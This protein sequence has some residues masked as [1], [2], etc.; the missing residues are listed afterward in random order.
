M[1]DKEASLSLPSG[2]PGDLTGNFGIGNSA[3]Q[4]QGGAPEKKV[5]LVDG[6]ETVDPWPDGSNDGSQPIIPDEDVSDIMT[7]D[8]IAGFD[9]TRPS[10]NKTLLVTDGLQR[11]T[12]QQTE[13][14]TVP[15][16]ISLVSFI[17]VVRDVSPSGQRAPAPGDTGIVGDPWVDLGDNGIVVNFDLSDPLVREFIEAMQMTF[18]AAGFFPG[19]T[20]INKVGKEE[21]ER[22]P[23]REPNEL[24]KHMVLNH[25]IQAN[26]TLYPIDMVKQYHMNM[27]ASGMAPDHNPETLR[28]AN[29]LDPI[30][31][32][33]DIKVWDDAAGE[34]PRLKPALSAWVKQSILGTLKTAGYKNPEDWIKLIVTGSLTTYQWSEASDLDVSIWVDLNQFPDFQ[35]SEMIKVIID[36][37][38]GNLVPGTNHPIQCFVVDVNDVHSPDEIYKTGVRSAYDLDNSEWIIKP[39]RDRSKNVQTEFP[40]FFRKAKQASAKMNLLLRFQPDAAKAYWH[41]LHKRR[42]EDMK[43]GFGDY[44][45]SNIVYKMLAND[46][47]FDDIAKATGEYIARNEEI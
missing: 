11:K 46:G 25:N 21:E 3:V 18:P 4:S 14:E 6:V 24:D 29:I 45:E 36:N 28:V 17:D 22:E 30:Q 15:R 42:R 31:E 10:D 37:L 9:N 44:S 26:T 47:L 32:T 35:R 38:D 43:A 19:V 1:S 23:L 16:A 40:D 27:H 34:T 12:P 7:A 39:E 41:F 33:L 5:R 2:V 13:K 8:E 20:D